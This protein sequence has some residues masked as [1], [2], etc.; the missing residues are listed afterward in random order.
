MF[1][2]VVGRSF[3]RLVARSSSSSTSSLSASSVLL[4]QA[5]RKLHIHEYQCH[6]LM[7][8]AGIS[9]PNGGVAETPEEAESVARGLHTEDMIVKAQV[10]TGGRGKG[11]FDNG[12]KGGVHICNTPSEVRGLAQKMLGHRLKTKQSGPEGKLVSKIFIGQRH[13]IRREMYFAI[14]MDR[15]AAG[16][17]LVGSSRGGVDIE[18]VAAEDPNAI[19]KESIDIKKGVEHQ[20]AVNFAHK[21]G[22][23]GASIEE[24]AE[25]IK[26]LYNLFLK[27]DATLLEINPLAETSSGNVLCV[28]AK[29]NFD[30]N[31]EFRQPAIFKL[32][33]HSQEDARDVAAAEYGLNYI[34]L[35]GDIGCLVNGA[36]LAMATM[37]IIKLYGGSPANFLDVGGGATEKQVSR[38]R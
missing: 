18:D 13:F 27:T 8:D 23:K 26:K 11:V 32:R 38:S 36:G 1:P 12:F 24:A 2:S 7:K 15:H 9:V 29:M 21:L 3:N 19:V 28:D 10:H 6:K 4:A 37:D 35:D 33:D 16:P 22:F 14:L 25:Q 17:V 5:Q 34:G 20:Q 30:D 31:A